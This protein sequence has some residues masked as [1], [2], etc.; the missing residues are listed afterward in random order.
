[1]EKIINELNEGVKKLENKVLSSIT[2]AV[3]LNQLE[4]KINNV[5]NH[6]LKLFNNLKMPERN[7]EYMNV[8]ESEEK[9]KKI[10]E[11]KKK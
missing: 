2:D 11:G 1:M 6:S 9:I 3:D 8:N 5:I 7:R 10:L 4:R